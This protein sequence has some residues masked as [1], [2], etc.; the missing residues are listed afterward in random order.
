MFD[1]DSPYQLADDAP[2]RF[3]RDGFVRLPG[4]LDAP[5]IDFFEPE[6]TSKVIELNTMHLPL[7]ERSTYGK[8]FLQVTN[9]WQHSELVRQFVLSQRLGRIA[10]ELMGVKGVRLYHDQALYKEADGGITP[11]HADQYYW[12]FSSDRTCTVWIPL[13]ETPA[14]MGPLEFAVGSQAFEFG[15]ELPISD[16]SEI[17]LQQALSEQGFGVSAEP[18]ALGDVS[19]H[20]GWTF[21]RA[22]P[23]TTAIPRRVMTIIYIDADITVTTPTNDN[24]RAD[25]AHWLAGTEPGLVPD[26]PLNPRIW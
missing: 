13:Q 1:I 10:A 12:P 25:L 2:E 23:N 17:A 19:F 6:I 22:G 7:A 15:R 16:E 14:G 8:A 18:Y 9:L 24:Q 21:H 20:T 26:T 5:T 4:V 11:W 3:E